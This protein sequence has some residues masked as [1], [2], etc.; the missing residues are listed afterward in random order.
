LIECSWKLQ[1]AIA[2]GKG[3]C[4]EASEW[5]K[6]FNQEGYATTRLLFIL[7][8]AENGLYHLE[9]PRKKIACNFAAFE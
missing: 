1:E 2:T 3:I 5:M 4:G 7:D 6:S 9:T 8:Q